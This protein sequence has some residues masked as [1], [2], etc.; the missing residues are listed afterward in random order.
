MDATALKAVQL[1]RQGTAQIKATVNE[2]N[3]LNASIKV[4]EDCALENS[5][6]KARLSEY[7]I[8]A[9]AED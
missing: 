5:K 2:H 9:K 8:E 4:L 3:A 1:L 7:E 6:L